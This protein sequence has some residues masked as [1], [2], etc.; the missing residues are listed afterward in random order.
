[1][2]QTM[3]KLLKRFQSDERGNI[4]IIFGFAIIPF[5]IAAGVSVDYGRAVV[6]K[7]K[8]QHAIDTAVLAAG[9]MTNA[10]DADRKVLGEVFFE[11]NFP[12]SE[13]GLNVGTNF[14]TINDNIVSAGETTSV[15]TT[16]MRLADIHNPLLNMGIQADSQATVPVVA[17]AEVALVL[18]FSGSMNSSDPA[19][20][21]D[22]Y[23]NMAASRVTDQFSDQWRG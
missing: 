14:I 9:S 22:K 20:P 16:L 17:N 3:L 13:Y 15:D 12:P 11:A 8:L 2:V 6:T 10:T 18:D 5:M 7:H 4:A 23:E 19:A 21:G 1:M